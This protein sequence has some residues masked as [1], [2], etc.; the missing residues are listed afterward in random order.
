[1][2]C[3]GLVQL[4]QDKDPAIH[5]GVC[6][7]CSGLPGAS[8]GLVSWTGRALA[9]PW[10]G[11]IQFASTQKSLEI[12]PWCKPRLGKGRQL[13]ELPRELSRAA[14]PS[15]TR[16][17]PVLAGKSSTWRRPRSWNISRGG[18]RSSQVSCIIFRAEVPGLENSGEGR[19][20][21]RGREA[22][23]MISSR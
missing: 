8:L 14:S 18:I 22:I 10:K 6:F 23:L 11:I 12:F 2:H 9:L 3:S 17:C 5:A 1:M 15:E 21:A 19:P 20:R 7:C 4:L 13:A 16:K